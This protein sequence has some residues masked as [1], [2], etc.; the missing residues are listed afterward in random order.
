MRVAGVVLAG[1]AGRRMGGS[2]KAF[3]TLRGEPLVVRAVTRL[4]P[5]VAHLAISANGD[6][7]RFA[8]LDLPVLADAGDPGQGPL[9]GVL[10]G[11]VWAARMGADTLATAAVDTPFFPLDFVA[12]CAAKA[13]GGR[14]VLV[15][16]EEGLHPTFGLWPVGAAQALRQALAD[17]QRKLR[18]AAAGIGLETARFEDDAAFFNINAPGDMAVAEARA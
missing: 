12:R 18:D 14:I 5:Q 1:G 8:D 7:A 17:G 15:E 13:S 9:A 6:A 2:D 4:G 11:L 16:T 10:A 3:M